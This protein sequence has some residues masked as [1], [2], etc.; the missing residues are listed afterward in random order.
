MSKFLMWL[1]FTLFHIKSQRAKQT[2]GMKRSTLGRIKT[3]TNQK[4]FKRLFLEKKKKD[5]F[6][7]IL[8]RGNFV[9][10]EIYLTESFNIIVQLFF[11][12]PLLFFTFIGIN[13]HFE[14]M[15]HQVT[16]S[17]T[18]TFFSPNTGGGVYQIINGIKW[19]RE[20]PPPPR[21]TTTVNGD[22]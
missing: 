7:A 10:G 13:V 20:T 22:Q 1:L 18:N 5:N 19:S 14:D 15:M 8:S 2:S 3:E 6:D 21:T 17:R 11:F 4:T 12:V 9:L 16:F